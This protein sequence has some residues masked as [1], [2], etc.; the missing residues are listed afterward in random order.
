M[1]KVDNSVIAS[2]NND[3]N[4]TGTPTTLIFKNGEY[5]D[6][7]VGKKSEETLISQLKKY[8]KIS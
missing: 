8:K 5:I 1:L 4:I 3:Y 6:E 7:L 2:I